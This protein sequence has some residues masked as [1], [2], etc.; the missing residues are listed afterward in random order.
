M[1][2]IFHA[3]FYILDMDVYRSLVFFIGWFSCLYIAVQALM[4][5]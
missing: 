4:A 2:R 1:S 3:L 5:F